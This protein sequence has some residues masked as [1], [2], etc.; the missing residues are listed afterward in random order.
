MKKIVL[1]VSFFNLIFIAQAQ[2]K[3]WV[4]FT[5]KPTISNEIIKENFTQEG[6]ERREFFNIPFDVKDIPVSRNYLQK[7]KS[8]G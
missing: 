1:F 7:L 6:I 4:Y 2:E 5:D 8:I 3:Y